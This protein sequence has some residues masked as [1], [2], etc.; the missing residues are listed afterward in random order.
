VRLHGVAVVVARVGPRVHRP[1]RPRRVV[2]LQ[3]AAGGAGSGLALGG[4]RLL[5][6]L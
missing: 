6:Q 4:L 2:R 1:R 3:L 5:L